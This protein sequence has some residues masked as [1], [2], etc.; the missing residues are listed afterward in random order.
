M[1]CAVAL[2]AQAPTSQERPGL[3]ADWDVAAVFQGIGDHAAGMLPLLDRID[4]K[5]WVTRG[6]SETYLVQLQSSKDQA[7]AVADAAKTLSKHPEQLSASLEIY[8]RIQGLETMLASL[9]EGL[10][11]YQSPAEA[12]SLLAFAGQ[13]G[14]NRDRLQKYLVNLSAERE[15]DL[16]IMD[17]EAQRCRAILT[18][19]AA[20][21]SRKR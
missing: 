13:N 14:A 21:T 5:S 20:K 19:P 11:K 16:Q 6:A 3:E 1:T 9:A 12:Q 15:R 7:R 4:A 8:F 17:R 18:E 2:I 10:R